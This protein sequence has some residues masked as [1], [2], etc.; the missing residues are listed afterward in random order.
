M[1]IQVQQQKRAFNLILTYYIPVSWTGAPVASSLDVRN[2]VKSSIV[3]G[4]VDLQLCHKGAIVF[5]TES[6]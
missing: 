3:A 4:V 2:F 1:P 5:S 6:A